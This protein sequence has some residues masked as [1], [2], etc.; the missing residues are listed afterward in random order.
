MKNILAVILLAL[1]AQSAWGSDIGTAKA[2][3]LVGEANT[4]YV[5]AVKTPPGA[6]IAALIA[7]VNAKRK[8]KFRQTAA[9]TG[10]T[11]EQVAYR[12]YELAVQKTR[13]GHYYQDASGRWKKK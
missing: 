11:V 4:G 13:P 2:Q 5:A 3:G 8:A 9:D 10:A 12:F 7:E 6:D 1:A